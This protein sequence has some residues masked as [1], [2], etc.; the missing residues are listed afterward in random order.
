M[1][2]LPKAPSFLNA[3][4]KKKYEE[5]GQLLISLGAYKLGDD[6][7]LSALCANY[8]RWITAERAIRKNK[9]LCFTTET[10]YR[11]QIPEISIANNAMKTMLAFVKALTLSNKDTNKVVGDLYASADEEFDSELD[12]MIVK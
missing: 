11:Q 9:D 6:I 2:E 10:G 1:I 12:E 3:E 5:I 7:I 8:Q 4:S